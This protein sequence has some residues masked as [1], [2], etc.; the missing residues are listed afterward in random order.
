MCTSEGLLET[1]AKEGRHFTRRPDLFYRRARTSESVLASQRMMITRRHAAMPHLVLA[2]VRTQPNPCRQLRRLST[3]SILICIA[4]CSHQ[5]R[6]E[7]TH[8]Q[9]SLPPAPFPKQGRCL[10]TAASS[11]RVACHGNEHCHRPCC[12]GHLAGRRHGH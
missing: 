11:R 4:P 12:P 2:Q 1:G 10:A 6:R 5:I 3:L 7:S 8:T 9:L